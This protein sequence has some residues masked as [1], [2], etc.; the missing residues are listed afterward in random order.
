MAN[1]SITSQCNRKCS[2]CFAGQAGKVSPESIIHMSID[3]YGRVLE[4]TGQSGISEIRLLGGEPTLHPDF[5]R[6]VDMA[7]EQDLKLYIFSNGLMPERSLAF[8]EH[9]SPDQVSILIN[10]IVPDPRN[11]PEVIQQRKT[12]QR[13]GALANPGVNIL[14]PRINL[15]FLLDMIPES[16]LGP[17]IRLG[18]AHPR[19]DGTNK[20]LHPRLYRSVGDK[21]IPFI[22]KALEQRIS[23]D[24]DC[25]FV[26]CMFS[27]T[28]QDLIFEIVPDIGNRCNPIP[29]LL[30]NGNAISCYP[31]ADRFQVPFDEYG[32]IRD[33]Q[34][35]FNEELSVY[36][37][38][39]V[40]PECLL[41]SHR[42]AGR[43]VG[44]CMSAAIRR[45]Y[46]V[47]VRTD[48]HTAVVSCQANESEYRNPL[49]PDIQKWNIP[50]ID[51]PLD[52]W[53]R[54]N[55][56]YG[57]HISEVYF[58]LP[59][60][61]FGSGRPLQA[62]KMLLEF[63]SDSSLPKA[64]II[65]PIVMARPV[66]EA[67]GRIIEILSRYKD[68]YGLNAVTVSDL[69]LA[70]HIKEALPEMAITASVL[71]DIGTAGQAMLTSDICRS[72]VPASRIMRSKNRLQSVRDAFAGKVRLL[73]NEGCIPNCPFRVQHF[74]E[75]GVLH[76]NAPQSLCSETL[77]AH[78]WMRLG[79]AWVLP[80]HLH[81]Y[82][83]LYD[84]LKLAGR[85]TLT[86]PDE[87][88]RVLDAYISRTVVPPDRIGAGPGALLEPMEIEESFFKKTLE[89]DQQC[90]TCSICRDYYRAHK[91][92]KNN[93][94]AAA[95]SIKRLDK[96]LPVFRL[97]SEE[98]CVLYSPGNPIRVSK[99]QADEIEQLFERKNR[100]SGKDVTAIAELI[101]KK[102]EA[103]VL[104]R[105]KMQA[106][107]FEPE[108][109]TLYPG[110]TC[111]LECSYCYAGAKNQKAN[112]KKGPAWSLDEQTVKAA[113]KLVAQNCA[114]KNLPFSLVLHGGKEP[115]QAFDRVRRLY[116]LTRE[117]ADQ[118]GIDWF[119]YIATNGVMSEEK[120]Q[121][122]ARS[123]S[124]IGISCDGPP[125]I[126]DRQ[127]PT[128]SGKPSSESVER[129]AMILKQHGKPIHIR[130][131]IT[132]ATIKNQVEI[133]SY[134][135]EQLEASEI[136]FEPVYG[137]SENSETGFREQDASVFFKYF[138]DSR[139]KAAEYGATLSLSGVRY[140]E[141]HGPYCDVLRN[142]LRLSQDGKAFSCFL[143][144]DSVITKNIDL[145]IGEM[146]KLTGKF[147]LFP[148]K[149]STLKKA[150]MKI[151]SKCSHCIN[152]YHCAAVCP[153]RCLVDR[154][155]DDFGLNAAKF[156]CKLFQ[157][158]SQNLLLSKATPFFGAKTPQEGL[159][160]K[161]KR[162]VSH[163]FQNL[164]ATVDRA[165]IEKQYLR[166]EK[167]YRLADHEMPPPVWDQ[168]GFSDSGK[169]LW[170]N[171]LPQINASNR[172]APMSIYIHIPFCNRKCGFCDCHSITFFKNK[173]KR[174]E[175]FVHSLIQEI[176]FWSQVEPLA[177]RPVTTLHFGGGTPNCIAGKLFESVVNEC[178]RSFSISK[179]TELACE[180]TCSQLAQNRMQQLQN[181]GFSRLHVGVQTLAD[182]LRHSIGRKESAKRVIERILF[183]LNSDMITSVDLLYG[184]P[185]QTPESLYDTLMQLINIKTLG[186]SL[187]R[188]NLSSRNKWFFNRYRDFKPDMVTDYMLFQV[189]DQV[190]TKAGYCK[191]YYNHYAMSQDKNLYFTYP[192]RGEDLLAIGPSADGVFNGYHYRHP[193]YKKYLNS[194]PNGRPMLDG[195]KVTP[196][197]KKS[198]SS[199]VEQHL[200]SGF[201]SAE[202]LEQ[203]DMDDTIHEWLEAGCLKK[204][205]GGY[206][207]TA[208]GAWMI[209]KMTKTL[210]V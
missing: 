87:Y 191:N 49:R 135:C 124:K 88:C 141:I 108:C 69:I 196:E 134:L 145:I 7:L 160:G 84:E 26:P 157:L 52:F 207:L 132:P 122:L 188:L 55:E 64:A 93:P 21:I 59:E 115:T 4:L 133:V 104:K 164:P 120:M 38:A 149:I 144:N 121:W 80:Q 165:S 182:H 106:S 61:P 47:P 81:L 170:Q 171:L 85:A 161:K 206:S 167:K 173:E 3:Q 65:N 131:T 194:M 71:M 17:S 210:P 1:I 197:D 151:D 31:L 154:K 129:S 40:F 57:G 195:R 41:C 94:V 9:Q 153:E 91:I 82:D 184:L 11:Q 193:N 22:K 68:R 136:V 29:D 72:L 156:R 166:L 15:D 92:E 78:P 36:R 76:H 63:L 56:R 73:V 66:N 126:Q 112:E 185:G 23:I 109:L 208:N 97:A 172:A 28:E 107:P 187:Y 103:S 102:A 95:P 140:R 48:D 101:R 179:D 142:V 32:N 51:Q 119:G 14:S 89:C 152:I 54:L 162:A 116:S 75:M 86:D 60:H 24:F 147:V 46:N 27:E 45:L 5:I 199:L 204:E 114:Q 155:K 74:Y 42:N 177:K 209:E 83:G 175:K 198:V 180:T 163:Y 105:Q 111:N 200:L 30:S 139:T 190:L 186:F 12:F 98:K 203:L 62:D 43:C 143:L 158:L 50:Y 10:T 96:E 79:G 13:L 183:S 178:Y 99:S 168:Y 148:D 138:M 130:T 169:L 70:R 44:G 110:S 19:L 100:Q 123:F 137:V 6:M 25:G 118:Y 37:N 67:A 201:I 90:H 18:L 146:D 205:A 128:H 174:E 35:R 176:R 117:V 202:I 189:A 34:A 8:L 159:S 20:F 181:L 39:G 58:P 33:I 125:A 127:R 53:D 113:A 77:S 2:Y 150:A 16:G 192:K